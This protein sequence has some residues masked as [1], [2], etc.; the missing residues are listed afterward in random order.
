MS[1]GGESH[2]HCSLTML[3]LKDIDCF[4]GSNYNVMQPLHNME[5]IDG[6]HL[7]YLA[8]INSLQT[9][10]NQLTLIFN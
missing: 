1:H 3:D 4:N 2:T 9:G 8:R 10:W 6:D 7:H 5:N